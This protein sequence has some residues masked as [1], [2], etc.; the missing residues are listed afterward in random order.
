MN[1]TA[2]LARAPTQ[3]AADTNRAA[4][5]SPAGN[6]A[7][8]QAALA[9]K[10]EP[11]DAPRHAERT[12]RQAKDKPEPDAP[13]A[14]D[15]ASERADQAE[16]AS[17]SSVE[18]P[19][20]SA[21]QA[22]SAEQVWA[23]L[24]GHSAA[25]PGAPSDD[26]ALPTG[27]PMPED[28][29]LLLDGKPGS[30]APVPQGAQPPMAS[31]TTA[32]QAGFAPQADGATAGG[33][34]AAALSSAEESAAGPKQADPV[35]AL[36]GALPAERSPAQIT[37]LPWSDTPPTAVSR[38]PAPAELAQTVATPMGQGAWADDLGE[39]ILWL[40][41]RDIST[42]QLRLNPEHLG[43]VNVD[44]RVDSEGTSIQFTAHN[45]G[46][47]EAIEAAVPKLREMFGAQQLPLT[48]VAV[49]APPPPAQAGAQ[50]F[51]YH[52]FQRQPGSG[53][54]GSGSGSAFGTGAGEDAIA[55]PVASG[56]GAVG[57]VNLFA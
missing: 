48:E 45:A 47:R 33:A 42:A 28:G 44:I 53:Q 27:D 4:P 12:T 5:E 52:G 10:M 46:T 38:A 54:P 50:G 41:Q 40:T 55:E 36:D 3:T 13:K 2:I 11:K 37:A 24:L 22:V 31:L 34:F 29:A 18:N 20:Q 26:G 32:T 43:P 14:S 23:M 51:D 19:S 21:P 39:R 49:T 35:A 25:G 56:K 6:H 16:S 17:S 30:A 9:R 1:P 57:L 7:D 8:F 15:R